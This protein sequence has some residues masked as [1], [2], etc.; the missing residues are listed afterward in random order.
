M[1]ETLS[2]RLETPRLIVRTPVTSDAMRLRAYMAENRAHFEPWDPAP[3]DGFYTEAFWIVRCDQYQREMAEGQALRLIYLARADADGPIVGIANF[4]NIVRGIFQACYL[5]YSIDR[6]YEGRGLMR[7]GLQAAIGY[8]FD[9]LGLHRIMANYQPTNERSGNLLRRL[10]FTIE[11]YA[12]D[13]LYVN[14]AWRDHILT[15]LTRP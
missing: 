11:G 13:Y 10:G 12:R 2:V 7:E 9:E 14:G 4:S 3:P 1:R 6:R 15:S 8:V 5:G